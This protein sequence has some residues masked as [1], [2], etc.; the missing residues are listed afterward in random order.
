LFWPEPAAAGTSSA[1]TIATATA[2]PSGGADAVRRLES[3]MNRMVNRPW[4]D[5]A[6][7]WEMATAVQG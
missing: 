7:T 3:D 6:G 5:G 4:P 2:G 1:A